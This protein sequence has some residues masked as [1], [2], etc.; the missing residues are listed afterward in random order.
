VDA[1]HIITNAAWIG[2]VI[3][4]SITMPFILGPLSPP[5]RR[6]HV[7][8]L[9]VPFSRAAFFCALIAVTTGAYSAT[10]LVLSPQDLLSSAYGQAL[11]IKSGLVGMVL[12]LGLVNAVFLK[13]KWMIPSMTFKSLNRW[14][15]KFLLLIRLETALALGV[16]LVTA[17]LTALPTPAPKPLLEG[18]FFHNSKLSEIFTQDG[19]RVFVSIAPN[20]TGW[21]R[22]LVALQDTQGHALTEVERVRLRFMLPRSEV[23]TPW[24]T[25]APAQDGLFVSEGSD[26]VLEGRWQIEIDI[27]RASSMD[28]RVAVDWYMEAF[29]ILAIDP[30]DLRTSNVIALVLVCLAISGTLLGV[31]RQYR[32]VRPVTAMKC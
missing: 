5:E 28:S 29:P 12:F 15:G 26:L 31:A 1:L 30:A 21:N 7:R 27:R 11:I 25:L 14:R 32:R 20:W 3:M 22:Y 18:Q 10:L 17:S 16:L 4:L 24:V 23:R 9:L 19:L 13:P 2:S 8:A 6:Y